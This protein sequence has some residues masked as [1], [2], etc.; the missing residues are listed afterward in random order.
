M[1]KDDDHDDHDEE[2]EMEQLG[3]ETRELESEKR[4]N[5]LGKGYRAECFLKQPQAVSLV[6]MK[7]KRKSLKTE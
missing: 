5:G 7:K 6:Q 3:R 4:Q 1:A 2:T